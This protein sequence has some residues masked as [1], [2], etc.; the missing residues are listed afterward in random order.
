MHGTYEANMA[1]TAATVMLCVGARFDD[2]ITGRIVAFSPG[3][4]Q[5]HID[6]D[7]S[8][9]NKNIR[10]DVPNHRRR[11]QMC[12]AIS[13]SVQGGVEEARYQAW[14]QEIAKWRARHSLSYRKSK[15]H[16]HAAYA[17]QRLFRGD[18]RPQTSYITTEVGQQPDVGGAVLRLRGAARW[19]T[20]GGL[21]HGLRLP[22][23]VGV[24]VAHPATAS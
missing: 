8:S 17:I 9:I 3:S 14:W 5:I 22:A 11:R 15:R 1:I 16:H 18:A 12:W 2:R 10:V 23:A 24:Q 21:A 4:K 13:C 7:P 6:I 19:M 20:S